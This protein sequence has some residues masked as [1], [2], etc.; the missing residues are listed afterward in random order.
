[1]KGTYI[2]TNDAQD[3]APRRM[4]PLKDRIWVNFCRTARTVDLSNN[5]SPF[6]LKI[7]RAFFHNA[8]KFV[9][10]DLV[11]SRDIA[12]QDLQ[13][14]HSVPLSAITSSRSNQQF[15]KQSSH[16]AHRRTY[17]CPDDLYQSFLNICNRL[18]PI[19]F[20]LES[21]RFRKR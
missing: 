3:R 15:Y 18:T 10:K 12:L 6:E 20:K 16:A 7:R 4:V 5:S 19:F 13:V 2:F 17:A 8:H 1:M 9:S 14:L 11:I 21:M